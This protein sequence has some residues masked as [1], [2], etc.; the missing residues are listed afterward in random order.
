MPMKLDQNGYN[1]V[2]R[3]FAKFAQDR[4]NANDGKAIANARYNRLDGRKILAVTQSLTDSVHNWTRGM[5]EWIANDRTRKLFRDAVVDMFGSEAKIPASVRKAMLFVDYDEGKPLTARRIMAVK[6]AIDRDGSVKLNVFSTPQLEE[7]ARS[8]GWTDAELPKIARAAHFLVSATNVSEAEAIEQLSTP[9][10][11]ANRLMN[12]GGRFM[13]S[14][15]NFA[16]GLR[17]I[18]GFATWYTDVFNTMHPVLDPRPADRDYSPANT[19]TKL[20]FG[21]EILYMDN[22]KGLE[23]FAM[24]ELSVNPKANLAETDMEKIFGFKNNRAMYCIGSGLGNSS[25]S[26]LANIPKEKRAVVYAALTAFTQPARNAREAKAKNLG[27]GAFTWL[28][29]NCI[30]LT[31]ARI[32]KNFDRAEEL[33]NAGKLTPKNIIREFFRDIPDNGRYDYRT[34]NSYFSSLFVNLVLGDGELGQYSDI[35]GQVQLAMEFTGCTFEEIVPM[36]RGGAMAP[37]PKHLASGS[38]TL[39]NFDG[40]VAGGRKMIGDDL[41][42]PDCCYCFASDTTT[43]LVTHEQQPGFGFT[44]PGEEKFYTNGSQQGRANITRVGDKVVEMCGAVHV[45]QANSVMTMLSQSGLSY[46]R[47]GLPQVGATSNEHAPVDFSLAKDARTG[48][49]TITYTSPEALPFKFSWTATVDVN[50]KVTVTPLAVE[51]KTLPENTVSAA[52][53]GALQ[54]TGVNLGNVKKLRAK[55]LIG[56]FGRAF[57][58]EGKKLDLFA[59]FVVRL[60]LSS[61]SAERDRKFAADMALNISKWKEFKVGEGAQAGAGAVE[62]ALKNCFNE[63]FDDAVADAAKGPNSSGYKNDPDIASSMKVD[64]GRGKYILNGKETKKDDVIPTFKNLVQS[65]AARQG[66]SS[67]L[68]QTSVLTFMS[69]AERGALPM[70]QAHPLSFAKDIPGIETIISRNTEK[71]GYEVGLSGGDPDFFY[72]L[73]VN[74]DGTAKLTLGFESDLAAGFGPDSQAKCGSL[75]YGCE[76]SIDLNGPKPVVTDAK[77]S[78]SFGI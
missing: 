17:L 53:D 14:A 23:K 74:D 24:E 36:L 13:D 26:T 57:R 27:N 56:E 41:D 19:F 47:G 62:N 46:L 3:D 18:D 45:E 4:L 28:G 58:L 61:Q 63:L 39:S 37:M 49:I 51:M 72:S 44:F 32:L 67:I 11:K 29:K 6:N 70:T 38:M 2:F 25:Y 60:K 30:V 5:N 66:L 75:K 50:G 55:Q 68:C 43:H 34:V 8:K 9:G 69:L 65:P 59:N 48:A 20:N 76:L 78:Q 31:I 40:T 16:N 21:K 71:G 42:R 7:L 35:A 22:L 64:V 73:D 12:Y 1:S 54:R 10:S 52:L 33:Y 15:A 77:L